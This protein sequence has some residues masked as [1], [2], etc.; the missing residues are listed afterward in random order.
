MQIDSLYYISSAHAHLPGSPKKMKADFWK[1]L[2][3]IQKPG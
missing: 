1:T 3:L 2:L